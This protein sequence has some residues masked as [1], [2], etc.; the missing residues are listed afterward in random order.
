MSTK[1]FVFLSV[2]AGYCAAAVVG[3]GDSNATFVDGIGT[4]GGFSCESLVADYAVAM[5]EAKRC[6]PAAA[7]AVPQCQSLASNSLPC[8]G[9]STHVHDATM[10]DAIRAKWAEA[11]CKSG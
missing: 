7:S 6:N 8:A 9:C 5:T 2:L 4:D 1:R 3:C 11:K 10:L